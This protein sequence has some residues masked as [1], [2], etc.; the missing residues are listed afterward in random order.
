MKKYFVSYTLLSAVTAI[1][2]FL[3][4]LPACNMLQSDSAVFDKV[5]A[6]K[7]IEAADS[8]F[9]TLMNKGDVTG[10]AN[11]YTTD[12]Q[13]M[14]PNSPTVKGRSN[15]QA[16]MMTYIES[17]ATKMNVQINNVWGDEETLVSEGTMSFSTNDG[18]MV[19]KSKYI[20]IYKKEDGR[21]K[22]FRDCFNSDLSLATAK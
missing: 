10:M 14:A 7:A 5:A 22:M 4:A 15:I 12:A 20:T 11:C 9:I 19:D 1:V 13:M 21:W 17:G 2:I 6:R 3:F 8:L 18:Q 16:A